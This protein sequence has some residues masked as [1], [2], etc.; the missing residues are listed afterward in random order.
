M[1]PLI[2][3]METLDDLRRH[4]AGRIETDFI[5]N[6]SALSQFIER[7]LSGELTES[8]L[9]EIGELLE[10]SVEYEDGNEAVIAQVLFEVSS[11]EANCQIDRQRATQWKAMLSKSA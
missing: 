6:R 10:M 4:L 11:P 5:L 1:T 9:Q 3:G 2:S 7:Y 8:E